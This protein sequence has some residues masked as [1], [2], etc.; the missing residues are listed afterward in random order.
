M[1]EFDDVEI[2][3]AYPLPQ[4]IADG[5]L[6]KLAT[7]RFGIVVKPLVA[8]SSILADISRERSMQVWDEYVL[9][10]THVMPRLPEEEQMF[11][12]KVDGNKVWV[13]EDG[14]AFTILYPSDY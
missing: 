13:L 5:V 8:T 3:S 11:V 12:T 1:G 9:W 4:A 14:E 6:V 7:I 10:R 2:I